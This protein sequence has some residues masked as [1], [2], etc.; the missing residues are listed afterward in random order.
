MIEIGSIGVSASITVDE[1]WFDRL[2][3]TPFLELEVAVE[4]IAG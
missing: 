4:F 2:V 3:L 1:R